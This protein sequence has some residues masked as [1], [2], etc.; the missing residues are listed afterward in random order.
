MAET[1]PTATAAKATTSV[2]PKK[3]SNLIS[4]LAPVLC[5]IGGYMIWRFILGADSGF[6]KPDPNGGFWP[7]HKGPKG[8]WYR[9]YEGG[10]IVPLQR[11]RVKEI[12]LISSARFNITWRTKMLTLPW[13]SAT[14]NKALLVT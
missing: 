3:S 6:S 11:L 4:I 5:I 9:M 8:A 2:Q 12:S 14:S 13:L 1:K 7:E 10:I